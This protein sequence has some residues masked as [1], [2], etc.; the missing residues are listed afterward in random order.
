M[1][2]QGLW[3]PLLFYPVISYLFNIIFGAVASQAF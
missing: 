3:F 1:L 2:P